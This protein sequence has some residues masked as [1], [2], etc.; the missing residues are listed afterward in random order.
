MNRRRNGSVLLKSG[1]FARV[2]LPVGE[3]QLAIVVPKDALVLGGPKPVVFVFHPDP[4]NPQRG[5]VRME[6]VELGVSTAD[7]IQA[8][9]A[10]RPGD[11]VVIRG[12]ERLQSGQEVVLVN[13]M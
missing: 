10:V 6:P 3:K 1:M 5:K 9:G 8:R 2:T 11:R 4:Q 7:L 13:R 12:N